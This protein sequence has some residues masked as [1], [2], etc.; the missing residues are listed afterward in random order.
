[1]SERQKW[2]SEELSITIESRERADLQELFADFAT[3]FD[4]LTL[5]ELAE[6]VRFFTIEADFSTLKEQDS[7]SVEAELYRYL[8]ENYKDDERFIFVS[9]EVGGE[10]LE[11]ITVPALV[12]QRTFA[13]AINPFIRKDP[14]S[15]LVG[16][17][18][19][20]YYTASKLSQEGLPN[21]EENYRRF[22]L[23][24]TRMMQ[25]EHWDINLLYRLKHYGTTYLSLDAYVSEGSEYKFPP[26][27]VREQDFR[28]GRI[29]VICPTSALRNRHDS[30]TETIDYTDISEI[31]YEVK[32]GVELPAECIVITNVYHDL[33]FYEEMLAGDFIPPKDLEQYTAIYGRRM[34]TIMEEYD[35]HDID[36]KTGLKRDHTR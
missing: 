26:Q 16:F 36:Y 8:E 34:P 20:T 27:E 1:M 19:T 10:K 7:L 29:A 28:C 32:V 11:F 12:E 23:H 22:Y 15:A 24:P 4:Q 30:D 35:A 13:V 9:T 17:H 31:P 2:S 21:P 25:E 5:D 6:V 18:D 3:F 33:L 14:R